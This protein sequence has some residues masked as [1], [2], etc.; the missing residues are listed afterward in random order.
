MPPAFAKKAGDFLY[1]SEILRGNG[2]LAKKSLLN[3]T[4]FFAGY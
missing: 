4:D 3:C 1:L 2:V